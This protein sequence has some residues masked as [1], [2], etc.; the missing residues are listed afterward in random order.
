AQNSVATAQ[1][2]LAAARNGTLDAQRKSVLAQL[3]AA[4]QKLTADQAHLEQ[5]VA[6][7]SDEQLRVAQN[8]IDQAM[9]AVLLARQPNTVGGVAAQQALV[10]Q[11]QQQ[12]LKAQTPYS[13]YDI[14]QQQH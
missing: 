12:L 7:P 11:A 4:R 13:D 1:A 5:L 9:Q 2:Q 14:A 6:G 3:D 10:E 8:A